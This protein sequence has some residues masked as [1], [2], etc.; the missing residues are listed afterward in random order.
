MELKFKLERETKGT[1]VY[2]EV[3]DSGEVIEDRAKYTIGRVYVMKHAF[4]TEAPDNMLVTVAPLTKVKAAT[5]K[6]A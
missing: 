5:R 1:Y 3:D 2:A 6:K 4:K